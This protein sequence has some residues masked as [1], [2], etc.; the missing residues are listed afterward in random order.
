EKDVEGEEAKV[1]KVEGGDGAAEASSSNPDTPIRVTKQ[2]IVRLYESFLKSFHFKNPWAKHCRLTEHFAK[3]DSPPKHQK[4]S[5]ETYDLFLIIQSLGG[6]AHIKSWSDIARRLG[7]DPRGTNIAAR[8]KDWMVYHHINS[9]FD[10]VM[11]VP[12]DFY[13]GVGSEVEVPVAGP[14]DED[15]SERGEPLPVQP[16]K[17]R[18]RGPAAASAQASPATPAAIAFGRSPVENGLDGAGP[19]RKRG[20]PSSKRVERDGRSR[21]G[22]HLSALGRS[23]DRHGHGHGHGVRPSR[24]SDSSLDSDSGTGSGSVSDSSTTTDSGSATSDSDSD[25]R[26]SYSGGGSRSSFSPPVDT[27][28]RRRGKDK[29]ASR[30]HKYASASRGVHGGKS[31]RSKRGGGASTPQADPSTYDAYLAEMRRVLSEERLADAPPNA[32]ASSSVNG[33]SPRLPPPLGYPHQQQQQQYQQQQQ[34]QQVPPHAADMYQQQGQPMYPSSTSP[35][36]YTYPATTTPPDGTTTT[37]DLANRCAFLEHRVQTLETKLRDVTCVLAD[38]NVVVR[39]LKAE[40]ERR[41]EHMRRVKIKL[42]ETIG[43]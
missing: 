25:S 36:H 35:G 23:S 41:D 33:H 2:N 11:G 27:Y 6:V 16:P 12:N 14:P 21:S 26:L 1:E 5:F 22:H 37:T 43:D 19:P 38:Q 13:T 15:E 40:I 8:V 24:V 30:S 31:H 3:F 20:R 17:K 29:K 9:F 4:R 18:K 28:H 32:A 42:W 39:G 10:Y 34:Q 7:F